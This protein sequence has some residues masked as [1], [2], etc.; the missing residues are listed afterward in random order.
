MII[1]ELLQS[2][3]V[4][5]NTRSIQCRQQSLEFNLPTTD[6]TSSFFWTSSMSRNFC[7]M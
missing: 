6:V 7:P 4:M 5:K 3:T 1:N 2:E